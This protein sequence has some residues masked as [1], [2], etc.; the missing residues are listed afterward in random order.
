MWRHLFYK[1]EKQLLSSCWT[2]GIFEET[3]LSQKIQ[4]TFLT[5]TFRFYSTPGWIFKARTCD[6]PHT[7]FLDDTLEA[8]SAAVIVLFPSINFNVDLILSDINNRT[9]P[10]HL[11]S[12]LQMIH[13]LDPIRTTEIPNIFIRKLDFQWPNTYERPEYKH[14]A[15]FEQTAGYMWTGPRL[16]CEQRQTKVTTDCLLVLRGSNPFREL[17][18]VFVGDLGPNE[19]V[20]K[21]HTHTHMC[22]PLPLSHTNPSV[23]CN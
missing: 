11:S 13:S 18:G 15:K 10:I 12:H 17:R 5:F 2:G 14:K 23:N 8:L 4:W 20:A 22:H 16:V 21:P 19:W 6:A 1:T 7:V 9:D 3:L